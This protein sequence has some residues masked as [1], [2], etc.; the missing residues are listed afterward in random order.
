[1]L[2]PLLRR[3]MLHNHLPD[4]ALHEPSNESRIPEFA[5]DAQ[6]LTAAHQGVGFAA[7]GGGRDAVR[8]EVLLFAAGDGYETRYRSDEGRL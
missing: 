1:M 8:V 3:R 2:P 5:G 7:L 6:V 4:M